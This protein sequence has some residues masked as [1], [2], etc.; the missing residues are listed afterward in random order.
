LTASDARAVVADGGVT[1]N[2]TALVYEQNPSG[3]DGDMI[4]EGFAS[5]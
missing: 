3:G 2:I 5:P 1:G 4:Y